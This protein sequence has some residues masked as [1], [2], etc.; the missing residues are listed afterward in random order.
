MVVFMLGAAKVGLLFLLKLQKIL[1][2]PYNSKYMHS[3]I[4]SEVCPLLIL[5]I[6]Y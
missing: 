6:Y 5:K 4:I 1:F 2:Y 3:Y